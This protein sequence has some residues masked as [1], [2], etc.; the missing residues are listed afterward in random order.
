MLSTH[1]N[2]STKNEKGKT[3]RRGKKRAREASDFAARRTLIFTQRQRHLLF[4]EY[5]EAQKETGGAD[6]GRGG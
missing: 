5:T 6:T 4:A 1:K 3:W 2:K